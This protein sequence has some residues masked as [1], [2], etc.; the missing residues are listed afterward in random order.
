VQKAKHTMQK[1]AMHH[2]Q[3]EEGSPCKKQIEEGTI[4]TDLGWTTSSMPIEG[5]CQ[6]TSIHLSYQSMSEGT[7]YQRHLAEAAQPIHHA[8]NTWR[9]TRAYA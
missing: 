8:T 3:I 5:S 9:P 2:T 6:K 1:E 7:L 4:G